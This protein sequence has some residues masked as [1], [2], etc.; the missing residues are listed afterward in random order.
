[1]PEETE[2][3]K[4][5]RYKRV[6]FLKKI[7]RPMPRRANLHRYPIIKWFAESAR[8]RDYLWRFHKPEVIR[9]IWLGW[10]IALVPIY[11]IQM[12]CAFVGSFIFRANCLVAMAI[13]WITN[14]FTILPFLIVQYFIGD[15]ILARFFTSPD[16]GQGAV[17]VMINGGF[18]EFIKSFKDPYIYK[19]V[20]A[21]ALLGGFIISILGASLNT[22]VYNWYVRR[23]SIRSDLKK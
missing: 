20:L 17:D 15:A 21:S 6:R 10:F 23:H 11:G 3:H 7:L 1:M 19:Y 18:W 12:M 13:Q 8:K 2:A 22:Y 5:K 9:A 14:P 4:L 16:L